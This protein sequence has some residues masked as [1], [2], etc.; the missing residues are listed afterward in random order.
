MFSLSS[1]RFL[2][3]ATSP[4]NLR[5]ALRVGTTALAAGTSKISPTS[6]AAA[7]RTPLS[8][9]YASGARQPFC[10]GLAANGGPQ[11]LWVVMRQD[12][13]GNAFTMST[14]G[15]REDAE[16]VVRLFE[17]R[18]HKQTYFVKQCDSKEVYPDTLS[19]PAAFHAP[20]GRLGAGSSLSSSFGARRAF[21]TT[22]A[23]NAAASPA[24]ASDGLP[25]A[26]GAA[27]SRSSSTAGFDPA[28]SAEDNEF[29]ARQQ[30]RDVP[31]AL[32]PSFLAKYAQL[33][34]PFGF[35]GLGEFVFTT[36]YARLRV[37]GTRETWAQ[38]VERVVT[39]T[40]NM[41]RKWISGHILGWNPWRAQRSAQ[42]MFDRIFHMKF[43]PPGAFDYWPKKRQ[44]DERS[45]VCHMREI[46][47][48]VATSYDHCNCCK[49]FAGRGLWA[50]GTPVTEERG[51]FA[52]LN[53]CAFVSTGEDINL[54]T[55]VTDDC[56]LRLH[57]SNC[58]KAIT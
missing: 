10:S 9:S 34:P 13:H 25:A 39:G 8:P 30:V 17:E 11:L 43:L 49:Y 35:N 3:M 36:R 23:S 41:Q 4:R 1:A 29:I 51:L 18:G 31:F 24:T 26:A 28:F 2:F 37:D 50:M 33:K 58:Q 45:A 42:E 12:D 52:A 46:G 15:T 48:Q 53:N 56:V 7:V 16:A 55:N 21:S 44:L 22:T 27:L 20:S 14:H 38:T 47:L 57:K 40:Y 5:A 54:A 6:K 19:A 32:T